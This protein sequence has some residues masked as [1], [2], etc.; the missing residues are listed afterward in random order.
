MARGFAC[1]E[2]GEKRTDVAKVTRPTS[3][4]VVRY[5]VCRGCGWRVVTE[6]RQSP[7]R[8]TVRR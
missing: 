6:E 5:R 2:C 3:G 1:P 7:L 4:L 8:K